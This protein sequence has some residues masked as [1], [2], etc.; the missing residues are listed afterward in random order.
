MFRDPAGV[1]QGS[2]LDPV[3]ARLTALA[4]G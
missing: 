3:A 4:T 1:E 2:N